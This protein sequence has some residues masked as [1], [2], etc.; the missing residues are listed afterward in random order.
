MRFRVIHLRLDEN[1]VESEEVEKKGIYGIIDYGIELHERLETY[2]ADPY[3]PKNVVVM[4]MGPFSGSTLPGAHRL[5]FFFRSPLYGTLFP[6]AMGGAAYAFK[7]VG[8]DF[9]TFGG[10]AEKPV[11][12]I[13]YN[14]GESVR[15]E[16][17][18]IE[19]KKVIEIWRG[20]RGEEGVY[21]LTQYLIDTF[22]ERFDFEYRIAVVGPASLNT[23][24]GAIFS[25]ALRRGERL[26][27]SEDWAARGGSGSV[28]LRAHNVVGIIFGG[29]P[30]KRTFPGEDIANFR[31]AKGI[32]EGVHKKP[33]NEIISEKTTKYRF[34]PKLNTG[35]TFGGNYPAEG[36]FVPVLNW[37][38]PYIEKEERI[39][40]H[41]NIMKHYWEP[42]NEEAIKPK[43]WTTCGEPCPVVCKKYRRGHHVEYEPYEANGP[44][45]GSISLRA[46]DISVHAVDA[47]GFDAIEFG[48]TAAWVLELIHRGLLKPEEVGISGKPEFTKEA[49]IERPVE[50]SEINAKLVAELAHRVAFAENEIARI[51]GLGKRK[52][53]VI[54]DER[55]KDRLKYGESFK[56]YGVFVPLGE[57]GEMTPT[58]YWAIGNYIPLP[59]QGRYWTF[60][61][62]GVF[63][64]PEELA[65]KIIAS[66]L[67]EFWYDNVGWCR[68]HRGWMKPVLRALFMDAYGENVDMEEHAKKQIKRL[69]EYARKAGYTPVFWDS[70]RVID[71]VSAGSEE[72]GNERWAEKF[73]LDKVGTAKEYLER[74]L[75]AYSEILGVEWRL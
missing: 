25:Q 5:M 35:G 3:N 22:G 19:L 26:V 11:V 6:S 20:Y 8:V 64:E 28:L 42:F 17:H 30:R 75:E 10:K 15:V 12:V 53:S 45:S 59:I 69:I 62:F 56:D 24:Y 52:A 49:L 68:F 65:Q 27:G 13:I 7:N 73:R 60:Y 38:M 57:N 58:M 23:N 66:A 46:S 40:I 1:K 70:M 31:T 21:A 50:A 43:N 39:K 74:V 41:E 9:V 54:L 29:K 32:V 48:G 72:F 55:F 63:L 18:E 4:G 44:L 67:W 16:L 2:S 37:Q 33:Y 51:I 14:N 34:N 71:L 36:D 61:Q 47:M